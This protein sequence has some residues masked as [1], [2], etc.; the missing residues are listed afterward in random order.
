MYHF[1][2]VKLQTCEA[3]VLH[4]AL[5]I[6]F[7]KC[8]KGLTNAL[9]DARLTAPSCQA[10]AVFIVEKARETEMARQAVVVMKETKED[11]LDLAGN[12]QQWKQADPS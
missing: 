2:K 12:V 1:K 11:K 7:D 6:W 8:P 4:A 5:D 9:Q 3:S 10:A